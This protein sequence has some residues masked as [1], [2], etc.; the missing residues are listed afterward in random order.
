MNTED[1]EKKLVNNIPFAV[2]TVSDTRMPDNDG[3]GKVIIDSL[4]KAGHRVLDYRIVP[5][6]DGEI[7][8]AV[9]AGV[10][11]NEIKAIIV[12]GGTGI[13]S[14]DVTIETVLPMLEKRLDGFGEY[15]RYLSYREIGGRG[16]MSRATGGVVMKKVI[17]C[18]PGST[19][20]VILAMDKIIIPQIGHMVW[21]ASR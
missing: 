21:E 5:D 4:R 18:I 3:S 16:I 13:S 19:K 12:N 7:R 11:H 14:R 20:A 9:F 1:H 15:F 17:L 8:H 2:V 6:D 10:E